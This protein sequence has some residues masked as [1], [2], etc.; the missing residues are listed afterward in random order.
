VVLA[1]ECPSEWSDDQSSIDRKLAQAKDIW[2]QVWGVLGEEAEYG[3]GG[4]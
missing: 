3:I 4:A 1:R 2:K